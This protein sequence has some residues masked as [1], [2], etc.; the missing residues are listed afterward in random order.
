M[1]TVRHALFACAGIGALLSA[2]GPAA[3]QTAPSTPAKV[4][5]TSVAVAEVVV[6]AERRETAVQSTP[7]AITALTSE[8]LERA[9]VQTVERLVQLTPSMHFNDVIGEAFL[10][11]RSVGGEPN[12]S[13]GGDPSVSFN[14]DGVYIARPTSVS[15]IL[16]DVERIEVLRGPQG[17]LYGRNATG[18]AIN[19]ITKAPNFTEFGGTADV[20]F[21]NYNDRRARAA[22]NI[23]LVTD[24]VALRLSAVSDRRDGYLKNLSFPNG[25]G[26][27][28]DL[29]VNAYRAQ[30]GF[31]FTDDVEL[32][33]R[34]DTTHRG[35]NGPMLK[36]QGPFGNP[37]LTAP[38]PRGYGAPPNP[39]DPFAIYQDQPSKFDVKETGVSGELRWHGPGKAGL[40]VIAAHRKADYRFSRDQDSSGARFAISVADQSA[41]QDT[42]EARL[43]SESSGP[44]TW[45]GGA[46]YFREKGFSTV[47]LSVLAPSGAV[48]LTARP[49]L[50]IVSV[51][52]A[53][54]G[55]ATYA[56]N[57]RL[58]LTGG[59][60]YTWDQK[61]AVQ[62]VRTGPQNIVT[63]SSSSWSAPTGK[64]TV[65]YKLNPNA[66]LYGT[67][68]RG[69]KAGGY[70]LDGPAFNPEKIWAYEAGVKTRLFDR[71]LQLNFSAFY[72]TQKD[73]Q[74]SQTGIGNSGAPVLIT[75]NAGAATTR[76]AE[77]EFQATPVRD[78]HISGSLTYLH[79]RYDQY[80]SVDQ[81]N[82][83]AGSQNL[84]GR[85]AVFAPEW[86]V[87]FDG[88]YRFNLGGL[89]S[90]EPGVSYYWA[91]K[92]I[93]R[94]FATP[95][96]DLQPAYDTL[97][98]RLL[99]RPPAGSWS[100]EAFAA[101]V[102]N[103][104]YKL[105]VS[106]G[107]L[108]GTINAGYAPPRTYGV[109]VAVDF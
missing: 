47:V 82:T 89:G 26:D 75:D 48:L 104:T 70:S 80:T 59:L 85:P 46:Y 57:D 8:S 25:S 10:S 79:A 106:A 41:Q 53:V 62:Y 92:Q 37:A 99:Y 74:V 94:V 87:S 7:I 4:A 60:R 6:T 15:S 102:G 19:V 86:T 32:T 51:S 29:D 103:T 108:T 90:L 83:A 38:P 66:F 1:I 73:L 42:V 3:A 30:L 5:E 109:K 97:D 69:Y 84:A 34:A 12:T 58:N 71:R 107:S 100:V 91:D 11:I 27:L 21:G 24:R 52:K 93:L 16:F 43:A 45:L 88:S 50:D 36:A 72:Y 23:P 44:L 56:L 78:L 40:T 76:G 28:N 67:I 96:G 17:T 54:F 2:A 98:L 55:Q 39:D 65:D 9:N 105:N 49:R 77:V 14:V 81:V 61:D 63:P 33:L 64:V 18:G 95:P 31:R 68:S 20:L 35:G 13:A 101:N 22:I